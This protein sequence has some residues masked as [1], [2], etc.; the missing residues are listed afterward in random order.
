VRYPPMS[1]HR[2]DPL[3]G[4]LRYGQSL[5][6]LPIKETTPLIIPGCG[7]R[8]DPCDIFRTLLDIFR[9]RAWYCPRRARYCPLRAHGVAACDRF[10]VF[11]RKIRQCA[12]GDFRR[13]GPRLCRVPVSAFLPASAPGPR[14]PCDIARESGSNA[15]RSERHRLQVAHWLYAVTP[16]RTA[17][18]VTHRYPGAS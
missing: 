12:D 18:P 7:I 6:S 10:R 16:A 4:N 1:V 3:V 17:S 15:G 2:D 9:K 14:R 8:I 11:C 13:G 5:Q